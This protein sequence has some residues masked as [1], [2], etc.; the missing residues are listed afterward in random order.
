MG[1]IWLVC[2]LIFLLGLT[3]VLPVLAEVDVSVPITIDVNI[4][5]NAS[6]TVEIRNRSDDNQAPA[7]NFDLTGIALPPAGNPWVVSNQYLR[8]Q[9]TSNYGLWG[10]RIVTDNEDLEGDANNIIDKIKGAAVAPGPDGLW[11]TNDDVLAYSGLLSMTEIAKP[12]NQQDSSKRAPLAWQVFA[13]PQAVITGP[14]CSVNAQG[15]LVDGATIGEWND[16]W[17]YLADKND[18]GFNNNILEDSDNDGQVDDP[19]YAMVVVGGGG[20]GGSLAQHPAATP[21]PGDGDIAIYLA[22]RFANTNWGDPSHPVA[23]L[24][25]GGSYKASLYVELLHE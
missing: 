1:K 19:T 18:G 14:T 16:D 15:V 3:I 4:P 12:L 8:V 6:L 9:Y 22:A 23:Y 11:G 25:P 2:G 20:G 21:K 13:S 7:I 24:L 10:V 5:A 17:A